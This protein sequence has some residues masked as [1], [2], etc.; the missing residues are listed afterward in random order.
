[1]VAIVAAINSG[2]EV[3]YDPDTLEVTGVATYNAL[4]AVGPY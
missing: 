1:M 4:D 3:N 2:T